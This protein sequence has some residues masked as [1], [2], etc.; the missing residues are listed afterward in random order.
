MVQRQFAVAALLVLALG[1]S[2]AFGRGEEWMPKPPAP[3][4]VATLTNAARYLEWK[5][6]MDVTDPAT[7][8]DATTARDRA[9]TKAKELESKEPWCV[10]KARL[11]A[12]LCDDIAIGM[13]PHDWFPA[14]AVW[15][16]YARP[17]SPVVWRRDGEIF[18]RF[19]PD[20]R[21]R[22]NEGNRTGRW[23]FWKDFDHSVPEW[24]KILAL[25]FPGLDRRL[26][27]NERDEPR[28]H[29]IGI[30]SEA[31]LRLLDRL[32]AYGAA[33]DGG[34]SPRLR[35]Q[36]ECL[37]RLRAGPPQ[38][39]YDALMFIYLYFV[40]S[41]HLDT[42]QCRGLSI[43]DVVLRPYY[44]ADLAA[45]RTTE[46][47]FREQFRHFLWQWGSID[48]YWGQPATLG[49]TKADG[50]T[51]YG[52]L[53][54]IILD[55][56]D[57]YAQSSPKF[58]LKIAENTPPA[59]LRKALDMARRHRAVAFCGEAPI[60]RILTHYGC[61]EDEARRFY[62][63]GCYEFCSPEGANGTLVGYVSLVK[64]VA[65]L[66]ASAAHG[67]F[68][69]ADFA[70]F[71]R[72]Y[73]ERI[74]GTMEE[75][76]AIAYAF[77]QH[78]D[79]VNPA[80]LATLA[81]ENAVK[82]GR[83]AFANGALRGNNTT[84]LTVGF[85]TTVDALMAVREIVYERREMSLS[86]LGRLMAKDW[87]G[88]EDLRLRMLRSPHKWGANDAGAND[89]AAQLAKALSRTVNGKPNS[90]GGQFLLSGH[91][92]R[93]FVIQGERLGATPDGRKAGDEVS[94]NLSPAVGADREGATAL[95][96]T[97]GSLDSRDWPGDFPLDVMLLGHAVT[98]ERGLDAMAALVQT[99]FAQGGALI[100]FNVFDAAELRDAQAHPEKYENLQVRVCGWNVRWN[101]LSKKEQDAYIQRAVEI[102]R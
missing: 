51:E 46:A 27:E 88:R 86:D 7:G 34:T 70:A 73:T 68:A 83:D 61:T 16:R 32:I 4:P 47:E 42:V 54:E 24:E 22:M 44:E 10:V 52:P 75:A 26:R 38:T 25:G 39:T 66:L 9:L 77:E 11:Y 35:K 85:G 78:L 72:A 30:V 19:N 55:V 82:T 13:S 3:P 97:L 93:Q 74:V 5:W 64:P 17:L 101:D 33:H 49:G 89:V 36:V 102:A 100:Q 63:V 62:T 92:A 40:C 67:T 1:G 8:I 12:D 58:H 80:N 53:S 69:A 45:G 57:D 14:F 99:Y 48:N 21:R 60:R 18:A 43:L 90:R 15:D 95:V 59:I 28:Y 76:M 84:I 79:D 20:E 81:S 23:T 41:E 91:C 94:K 65:D 98:G 56:I 71:V 87:S 37:K 31:T 29:A 50:S 96:L 6:R 2:V